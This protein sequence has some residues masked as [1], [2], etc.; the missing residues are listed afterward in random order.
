MML[1]FELSQ[2]EV[3]PADSFVGQI[4][5]FALEIPTVQT[6]VFRTSPMPHTPLAHNYI[7]HLKMGRPHLKEDGSPMYSGLL[8]RG[9]GTSCQWKSGS[10][11][12]TGR[13]P[14]SPASRLLHRRAHKKFLDMIKR[15]RVILTSKSTSRLQITIPPLLDSSRSIVHL[16]LLQT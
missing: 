15:R 16:P 7:S 8:G 5:M 9:E 11:E 3:I 12:G 14:T 10:R 6:H 2:K 13:A 1:N 4:S